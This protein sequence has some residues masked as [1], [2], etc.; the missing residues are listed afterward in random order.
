[1]CCNIAVV[2][3]RRDVR[4]QLAADLIRLAVKDDEV[5]G[6]I[7]RK[8]EIADGV[9]RRPERQILRKSVNTGGDERKRDRLTRVLQR[10]RK[11][12]PVAGGELLT[13]SVRAAAPLRADRV[14]D[15]PARQRIALRELRVPGRAAAKRFALRQQLRTG[16]AV[17]ATVHP[18]A[19]VRERGVCGVDD[20]IDLHMCNVVSDDLQRH[21]MSPFRSKRHRRAGK[22]NDDHNSKRECRDAD[23]Y[24]RFLTQSLLRGPRDQRGGGHADRCCR[25]RNAQQ[26]P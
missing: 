24:G 18:T 21:G 25:E 17:D 20:G 16:G 14:D 12:R 5:D 8:Q 2:N 10:E 9:D 3:I 22:Q 1:M 26:R 15:V 13:L 19:A 23:Q 7:V 6:H 4:E 11:R